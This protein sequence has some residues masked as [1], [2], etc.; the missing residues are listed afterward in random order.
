MV[1]M[2]TSEFP[3]LVRVTNSEYLPPTVS[4]PKLISVALAASLTEDV[5]PVPLIAIVSRML[6]PLITYTSPLYLVAADGVKT[7]LNV[8]LAPA[9]IVIGDG[10]SVSLNPDTDMDTNAFVMLTPLLFRT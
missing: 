7:T 6:L 3:V 5:I 10:A 9:A 4:L 1:E 8:M 2:V